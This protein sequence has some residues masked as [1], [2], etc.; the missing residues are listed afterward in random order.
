M[1]EFTGLWRNAMMTAREALNY[2]KWSTD[3]SFER[4][5][6]LYADRTAK[7]GSKVIEG[8]NIIEIERRYFTNEEGGRMPLYKILEI[9]VDGISVWR[10]VHD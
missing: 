2:L 4:V 3:I 10:R 7:E 9:R 1:T 5:T 8:K 6:L